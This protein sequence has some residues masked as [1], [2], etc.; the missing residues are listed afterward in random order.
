MLVTSVSD[1]SGRLVFG[2]QV[3][4]RLFVVVDCERPSA[5]VFTILLQPTRCCVAHRLVIGL[6][7]TLQTDDVVAPLDHGAAAGE[8]V[9]F[10]TAAF[11]VR[12]ACLR[13]VQLRRV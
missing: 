2:L 1:A 8:L 12:R 3:L 4:A 10:L 6:L 13:S 5:T 11:L 7:V 9:L